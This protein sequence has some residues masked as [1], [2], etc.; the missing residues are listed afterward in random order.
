[1][2]D[3]TNLRSETIMTALSAQ[4][5]ADHDG[6]ALGTVQQ[7][8]IDPQ[9]GEFVPGTGSGTNSL[10]ITAENNGALTLEPVTPTVENVASLLTASIDLVQEGHYAFGGSTSAGIDISDTVEGVDEFTTSITATGEENTAGL[11]F[12]NATI[13]GVN[14]DPKTQSTDNA[15]VEG[16]DPGQYRDDGLYVGDEL[17]ADSDATKIDTADLDEGLA[18]S[19]VAQEATTT[20]NGFAAFQDTGGR[21]IVYLGGDADVVNN[22]QVDHDMISLEAEL[23]Q[24]TSEGLVDYWASTTGEAFDLSIYE[25]GL[26]GHGASKVTEKGLSNNNEVSDLIGDMFNTSGTY[27]N[28]QI[29]TSI[30]AI[31]ADDNDSVTAIWAHTQS[32]TGDSTVSADELRLLATVHTT[33]GEFSASNLDILGYDQ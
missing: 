23:A 12:D 8:Y 31:T 7:G 32:S 5:M 29:N 33:G 22:F 9:S 18:E 19:Q 11:N 2:T 28:G 16:K 30:F 3:L 27:D 4:I 26:V 21:S 6:T 20:V 24:S 17:V 13:V 1:M 15:A 25:F 14:D 10:R